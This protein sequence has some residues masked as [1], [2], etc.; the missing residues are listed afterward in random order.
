MTHGASLLTGVS[1]V[2]RVGDDLLPWWQVFSRAPSV[3]GKHV[4][5]VNAQGEER[6]LVSCQAFIFIPG[7][8][9]CERTLSQ[10]NRAGRIQDFTMLLKYFFPST[11]KEKEGELRPLVQEDRSC[12]LNAI[13]YTEGVCGSPFENLGSGF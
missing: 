10:N 11:S 4:R 1:F 13:K 7:E 3:L 12:L 9:G 8:V 6:A 5:G 2:V